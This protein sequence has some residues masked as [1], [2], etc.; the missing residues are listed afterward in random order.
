MK[1]GNKSLSAVIDL[2]ALGLDTIEETED[3]FSIGCMVTLRQMELHKGFDH[4]TNGA[5]KESVCHIVGTQFRNCA[6][7]G[8][9]IYGRFGFSDVLTL[10]LVLDADVELF[11][12]GIVPIR[13]FVNMPK[14]NDILVRI[15]VR[16]KPMHIVYDAFRNQS[17]DF[18]VLT[19]ACSF[20]DGKICTAVGARPA[21][22]KLVED[23]KELFL[24]EGC[25][26][27]ARWVSEQYI[28][29]SNMRGSAAYRK[30]LAYVMTL[31]NAQQ[32]REVAQW[33]FD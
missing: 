28:Y 31:R 26:A 18:P 12:A 4:Y 27:Y 24:T 32:I 9:S 1:L 14:D 11:S 23:P 19:C 29:E 3:A 16:K 10:F 25:E 22:A 6:T 7:V 5:A 2:S 30:H 8:G 15:I 20:A 33:K 21:R 17:T 13:E